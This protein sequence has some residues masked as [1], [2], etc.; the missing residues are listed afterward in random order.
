[1]VMTIFVNSEVDNQLIA[2]ITIKYKE[3]E[4]SPN[5]FVALEHSTWKHICSIKEIWLMVLDWYPFS[6]LFT[7]NF[8]KIF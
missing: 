5:A 1:M 3:G 6:F 4:W 8:F 7:F 2:L